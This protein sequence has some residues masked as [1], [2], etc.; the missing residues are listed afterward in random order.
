M[1]MIRFATTSPLA[2]LNGS[3]WIRIA[4]PGHSTQA[5]EVK[6]CQAYWQ[7]GRLMT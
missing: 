1:P 7:S 6:A 2:S 4:H 3:I 5:K